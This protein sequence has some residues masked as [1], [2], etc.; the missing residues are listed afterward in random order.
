VARPEIE[1]PEPIEGFPVVR[2]ELNRFRIGFERFLWIGKAGNRSEI[3]IG[4]G[5]RHL[6]LFLQLLRCFLG[7]SC[8]ATSDGFQDFYR[9]FDLVFLQKSEYLPKPFIA[10][11]CSL[12]NRLNRLAESC[13]FA[14][15]RRSLM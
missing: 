13:P 8:L 2:V 5:R 6:L 15:S 9:I 11:I 14:K 10:L 4:R 7:T 1:R 3:A 12:R